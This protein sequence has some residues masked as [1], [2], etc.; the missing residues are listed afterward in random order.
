ME[1]WLTD[2]TPRTVFFYRHKLK[3]F[4]DQVGEQPL[5]TVTYEPSPAHAAQVERSGERHATD[6]IGDQPSAGGGAVIY[7]DS[8]GL[9]ALS[10][11]ACHLLGLFAA[12][13][14]AS[15]SAS[16]SQCGGARAAIGPRTPAA[17]LG[18]PSA[19]FCPSMSTL[20]NGDVKIGW[21]KVSP[22]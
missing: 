7:Q 12:R 21:D 17:I 20:A 22:H 9:V 10:L 16:W 5:S 13:D 3:P 4:M 8:V 19:S 14:S 18:I 2:R 6:R 11:Q 1:E 15:T